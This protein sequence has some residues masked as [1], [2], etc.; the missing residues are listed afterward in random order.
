MRPMRSVPACAAC[1]M[2]WA[3][4]LPQRAGQSR[5]K[6]PGFL[7]CCWE[8]PG[9]HSSLAGGDAPTRMFTSLALLWLAGN[10]LR[11]TILAV[12][13][14]IPLIHDELALSGTQVGILT[15][16]PSMLLAL[17]AVPGSLLIARFGVRA[18]MVAGLLI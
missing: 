10:A 17:A 1:M 9:T 13:P 5:E 3:M 7:P 4:L 16:L 2:L 18:A 14:G 8:M 15:G 6:R 11:L 12:P